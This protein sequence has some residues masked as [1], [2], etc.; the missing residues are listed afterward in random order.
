MTTPS[1]K[2]SD[3][4]LLPEGLKSYFDVMIAAREFCRE[5][6]LY[7]TGALR[8]ELPII[9]RVLKTKPSSAGIKT[10]MA[11]SEIQTA[12]WDDED[13]CIGSY[14]EIAGTWTLSSYVWWERVDDG[15]MKPRAVGALEGETRKSSEALWELLAPTNS[16]MKYY[17]S[18]RE[19]YFIEPIILSKTLTSGLRN[20][21]RRPLRAWTSVFRRFRSFQDI[22]KR[23]HLK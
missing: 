8:Q 6:H 4:T 15:S 5:L 22:R 14:G 19:L 3:P 17:T 2:K 9:G 20:Q 21:V 16:D 12:E 10:F 11:P 1:V 18:S 13:P 23:A 7:T